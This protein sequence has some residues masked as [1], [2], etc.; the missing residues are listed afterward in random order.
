M[1]SPPA[2]PGPARP[3]PLVV[4]P[5]TGS[6]GDY[7]RRAFGPAAAAAGRPLLALEPGDDLVAGYHRALDEAARTHG[8]LLV[9]GVSIGASIAV[10]WAARV[11]ARRCAGVW[12]VLPP[13][14][15]E[16]DGSPAAVSATTTADALERD[17]LG[18]TIAA[19]AASSPAWLAAELARSWTALHPGLIASL[20][21]AAALIGPDP[22]TL[23]GLEVPLAV[24]VSDDDPIHPAHVGSAWAEAAPC[25]A[26]C[27][28]G[29]EQW[30]HDPALLGNL[31]AEAW[32]RIPSDRPAARD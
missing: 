11:G 22:A 16:P 14:S 20:R 32:S 23:A 30:G 13:W 6:D 17:G 1:P 31:A 19:M 21:A 8:P 29:L 9:G 7:A 18:P 12:A 3:G 10:Q 24:V 5:G 28:I 25:A 26:L 4:M 15:G 27:R 2:S